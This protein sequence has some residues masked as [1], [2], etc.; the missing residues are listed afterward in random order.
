MGYDVLLQ[1]T[2]GLLDDL[3]TIE[4]T[5]GFL[6]SLGLHNFSVSGIFDTFQSAD[7]PQVEARLADIG[8]HLNNIC[9]PGAIKGLWDAVKYIPASCSALRYGVFKVFE[10]LLYLNHRNQVIINSLDIVRSVFDLFVS[11]R[12]DTASNEKE[13]HI[14]QRILRRTLDLGANTEFCRLI[15]EKTVKDDNRLD[16]DALDVVRA[17]M[18]ARWPE[19]FSMEPS[20]ALIMVQETTRGLPATGF[21]FM[22]RH[23][24]ILL[25]SSRLFYSIADMVVDRDTTL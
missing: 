7:I 17:G 2:K 13:R 18:R 21:T 5:L 3:T 20:A 22:V 23:I 12:K 15:L 19:H 8:P 10:R 9:Q 25:F 1:A 14:L 6:L 16:A 24:S 4:Q 11:A